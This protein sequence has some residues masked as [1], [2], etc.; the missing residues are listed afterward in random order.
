MDD[1]KKQAV[2]ELVKIV[3]ELDLSSVTLLSNG[4]DMLKAKER[5]EKSEDRLSQKVG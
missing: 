5:L 3:N 2:A 4:A 1:K